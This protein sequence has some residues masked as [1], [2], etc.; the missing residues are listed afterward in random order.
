MY[1]AIIPVRRLAPRKG[2]SDEEE[3]KTNSNDQDQKDRWGHSDIFLGNGGGKV[4]ER[5]GSAIVN[6]DTI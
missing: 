4:M 2:N 3:I 1:A 5:K 6:D